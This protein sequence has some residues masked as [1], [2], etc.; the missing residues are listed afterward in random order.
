[1]GTRRNFLGGLVVLPL[2]DNLGV[3]QGITSYQVTYRSQGLQV[4]GRL[5]VPTTSPAPG[6]LFNH[7][8]VK[9]VTPSTQERCRELAQRG[10]VVFAPSFRGEDGSEGEI[11]VAAGEVADVLAAAD[12][13]KTRPEVRP[14][15]LG[16]VGTSH[17]ALVSLLCASQRPDLFGAVVFGYG[18]ADIYQWYQ[19]LKDTKQLGSDP[20]TLR[21]YGQGPQ[22]VPDNFAKRQGLSVLPRIEAPVLIL[23]G[24][25]DTLV[26]APQAQLLYD[27]L[28]A[29][30]KPVDLRLYPEAGHGFLIYR[31]KIQQQVGQNSVRYRESLDAWASLVLFLKKTLV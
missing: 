27:R 11:E 25:K 17:G 16:I 10:F 1:M 29:L 31:N 12:Y 28:K 22:D 3:Q 23:Q 15:R 14:G 5:F 13:L 2:S 20:L 24:A 6:V 18:V 7:D 19:F 9:G 26:P 4:K 30:H 21:V 8:G